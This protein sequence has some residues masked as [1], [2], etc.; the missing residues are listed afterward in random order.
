LCLGLFAAACSSSS[1]NNG[2]PSFCDVRPILQSKC[3]RCHQDPTKNGAPFPLLSYADTQVSA[4]TTDR[5]ERKRYD[6]M[7][8]AVESG[9]MPDRSQELDPPVSP[10]TCEEKATLLAWLRAGAPPAPDGTSE[11]GSVTPKLSSCD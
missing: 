4:A 7:R 6:Q 5:P 9:I 10:L 2:T 8:S 1:D 3:Q 11:C